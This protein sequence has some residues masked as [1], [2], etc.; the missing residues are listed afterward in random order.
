MFD[1]GPC[2]A[3]TTFGSTGGLY[4]YDEPSPTV[5]ATEGRGCATDSRRASR[6]FGRRLTPDECALLQAWPEVIP[7]LA[8]ARTAEDRYRIVGNAVPPPLARAVLARLTPN[9]ERTR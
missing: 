3:V 9:P 4:V 7:H 2:A 6:V 5:T 8:T 1:D